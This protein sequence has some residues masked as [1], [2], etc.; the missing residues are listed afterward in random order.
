MEVVVVL[1][2]LI[3]T[4]YGAQET[5]TRT[6][7]KLEKLVRPRKDEA[8]PG[9][10]FGCGHH[11]IRMARGHKNEHAVALPKLRI[12]HQEVIAEAGANERS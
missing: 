12:G 11:Q 10:R 8:A 9:K 4:Q 2:H 3:K 5:K 1:S 7:E 6:S